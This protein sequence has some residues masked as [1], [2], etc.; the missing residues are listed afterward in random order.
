MEPA[1]VVYYAS[2]EQPL[3]PDELTH[4]LG[5]ALDASPRLEAAVRQLL[6]RRLAFATVDAAAGNAKPEDRA[7][8][9]GRL[10]EVMAIQAEIARALAAVRALRGKPHVAQSARK[11][12]VK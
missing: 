3:S 8:A 6:Q 10:S 2:P 5:T 4:A 1:P 12:S 9:G 11:P 7:H